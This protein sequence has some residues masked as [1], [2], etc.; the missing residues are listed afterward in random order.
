ME[1][2]ELY[3]K[4]HS[5]IPLRVHQK[6]VGY[7]LYSK[8]GNE[9]RFIEVKGISESWKTYT[10]QSLHHTEIEALKKNPD[11]FFLYIIHFDV[12]KENRNSIYLNDATHQLFIISGNELQKSFRLIP[13]S[14]ALKPI[15]QRKL[16]EYETQ[17]SHKEVVQLLLSS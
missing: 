1:I 12:S 7:D 15:S 2:A 9:E 16:K 6:G 8:N 10:W 13:E 17:D 11:K 3:E 5:R 14:Y 4:T